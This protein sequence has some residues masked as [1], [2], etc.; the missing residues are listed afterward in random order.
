MENIEKLLIPKSGAN[1]FFVKSK[2]NGPV[3]VICTQYNDGSPEDFG[4]YFFRSNQLK[5]CYSQRPG[6][7]MWQFSVLFQPKMSLGKDRNLKLYS[8]EYSRLL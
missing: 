1:T 8:K 3:Q 2:K 5:R 7:P 6:L 4:I